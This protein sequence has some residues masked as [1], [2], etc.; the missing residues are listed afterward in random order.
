MNA[1][2]RPSPTPAFFNTS[3]ATVDGTRPAPSAGD[4]GASDAHDSKS[5]RNT[6]PST[7]AAPDRPSPIPSCSWLR[8]GHAW[9]CFGATNGTISAAKTL[10]NFSMSWPN[11]ASTK[12][13]LPTAPSA[14]VYRKCTSGLAGWLLLLS[15]PPSFPLYGIARI[16]IRPGRTEEMAPHRKS[17]ATATAH[18]PSIAP[19]SAPTPSS[20][21]APSTSTT[22]SVP[23]ALPSRPRPSPSTRQHV[24][25][26]N[27][28]SSLQSRLRR[29]TFILLG[30]WSFAAR[31]AS[32]SPCTCTPHTVPSL[33]S[34][35]RTILPGIS[36]LLGELASTSRISHRTQS[37]SSPCTPCRDAR[38]PPSTSPPTSRNS[39]CTISPPAA[40]SSTPSVTTWS[41][42]TTG[43]T[44][45]S[46]TSRIPHLPSARPAPSIPSPA[47][48]P[49]RSCAAG[50]N[51]SNAL[52]IPT[53][54]R[55]RS[56]SALASS[57]SLPRDAIPASSAVT[58]EAAKTRPDSHRAASDVASGS[59]VSL[60]AIADQA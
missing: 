53:S 38:R 40:A 50:L 19:P 48:P 17:T 41:A 47:L 56:S 49:R 37:S 52:T 46:P 35:A 7:A 2:T 21:A 33:P 55:F 10:H 29:W 13:M 34:T 18:R 3:S 1:L 28:L 60:I 20:G 59:T 51:T 57:A 4:T 8:R 42:V 58:Y 6:S 39:I 43:P 12:L 54:L 31:Y 30:S 16:P 36:L 45:T 11:A 22:A 5:W 14:V 23:P 32:N 27:S 44:S 24:N 15:A 9:R 26:P 25:S